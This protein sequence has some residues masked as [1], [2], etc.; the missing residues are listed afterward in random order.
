MIKTWALTV[1]TIYCKRNINIIIKDLHAEE[2]IIFKSSLDLPSRHEKPSTKKL[3]TNAKWKVRLKE[4]DFLEWLDRKCRPR[5]F[6]D[7]S[8]K[9]NPGTIRVGGEIFDELGSNISTYQ[10]G[11]RKSSNN[12]AMAYALLQGLQIIKEFKFN[13]AMVFQ[14]SSIIIPMTMKLALSP[15]IDLSKLITYHRILNREVGDIYFYHILRHNNKISYSYANLACLSPWSTHCKRHVYLLPPSLDSCC[16][17]VF[18]MLSASS[19]YDG[20]DSIILPSIS[21]LTQSS[22]PPLQDPSRSSLPNPSS[23]LL[24]LSPFLFLKTL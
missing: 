5:L 22:W 7:G 19:I 1:E 12:K 21:L 6:F 20:K 10:W 17:P 18:L 8:S 3:S 16:I 15:N 24:R 13:N 11:L 14:D 23:S 4:R 2:R 9:S